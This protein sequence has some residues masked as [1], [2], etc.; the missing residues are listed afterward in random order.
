M[1]K[2]R[3]KPK[4]SKKKSGSKVV[5]KRPDL[6]SV[7]VISKNSIKIIR[8]YLKT[9]AFLTLIY[10]ILYIIF[11]RGISGGL[12]LSSL[13][14]TLDH[15]K[16]TTTLSN[17]LSLFGDLVGNA[18]TGQASSVNAG[19]YQTILL[20]VI[21][22]AL[23]WAL[24]QAYNGSKIRA[25]DA[26]YRG[27]Y[28]VI[29][30]IAVLLVLGLG[31]IPMLIGGSIY[32]AVITNGIAVGAL[33]KSLWAL[34]FAVLSLVSF[35]LISSTI[36]ALYIVT[37][38]DMTPMKAI[39]SA[40]QLVKRRRWLVMRKVLFL[41]FIIGVVALIIMVPIILLITVAASW[42]FLIFSLLCLVFIISYLYAL[43]RELLNE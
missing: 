6:P 15:T 31:L 32:S 2:K 10:A 42:I 12:N 21:S 9:F 38:P 34:M 23:I 22:L 26:F 24:R 7:L 36:F 1:L 28:P 30:F 4:S 17:G 43:Y 27:M 14:N 8:K 19:V 39:R 25:R 35:Y 5:V 13:R 40:R 16:G 18:T 20:I 29:P 11:I 3:Q 41:P 37:L 33:E